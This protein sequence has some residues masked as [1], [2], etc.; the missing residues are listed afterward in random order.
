M[1]SEEVVLD[2]KKVGVIV[3]S[4]LYVSYR[5]QSKHLYR[6][7]EKSLLAAK[8]SGKAAWGMSNSLLKLLEARG[9]MLLA[10]NESELGKTYY[11]SLERFNK[12]GSFLEFG[13]HGLQ[14]FMNLNS[15]SEANLGSLVEAAGKVTA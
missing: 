5:K 4:I 1:I 14:K 7:G 6:G 12:E 2:G 8:R 11:A 15:W 10:I 13:G 3:N 9:V